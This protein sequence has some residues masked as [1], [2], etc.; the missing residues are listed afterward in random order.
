MPTIRAL[1]VD[2]EPDICQLAEITL[3]RMNID[4][5]SAYNLHDARQLLSRI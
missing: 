3:N 1:I 5:L 2:D 4:T